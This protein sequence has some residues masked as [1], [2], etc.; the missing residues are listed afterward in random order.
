[1]SRLATNSRKDTL[2]RLH[3]DHYDLLI[4]GGGITGA[5]IALDAVTRGLKVALIEKKDF[6]SGTSSRSTKLIHG[7]LRY[8]KQLEIQLVREVGRERAI[9]H[10]LAPHLVHAEKMLMPLVEGGTYGKLATA[11]GLSV[12]DFLAKVKGDDRRQMLSKPA[13]LEREPLLRDDILKGGGYYAEYRTD[14]ARLTMAILK[15]AVQKGADVLNYL[16]AKDFIYEGKKLA[17]VTA[18][19]QLTATTIDIKAK[20]IV[21]AAGPWVDGLREKDGSK[22][23]KRLFLSKGVHIVVPHNRLPVRQT[24]YFDVPDGR[25]VFVIPRLEV[26]YIGTT[27]TEYKGNKDKVLA[28]LSDVDYLLEAANHMFPSID[29]KRKDV[30]SSWAGLRPL[31]HEE[32]KSASEMSRKD[33]IFESESGLISIAGG[34]LTGYRKMAQRVVDLVADRY[35]KDHT[36]KLPSCHTHEVQLAG[37][38]WSSPK[39]VKTYLDQFIQKARK[40]GLDQ[41]HAEYLV[42]NYGK[43]SE[44]ILQLLNPYHNRQR[45]GP[46][47]RRSRMGPATRTDHPPPRLLQP[48]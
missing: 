39:E 35:E 37:G 28:D 1:M 38:P 44:Q 42:Y 40:K 25:M 18:E 17:A 29:L 10:N 26:T 27:D 13:T 9:V 12:Y 23:G 15:T 36:K 6:A 22:S 19:D 41:I 48:P 11:V 14:D 31:I 24:A 30:V 2:H 21:S 20:Y 33:E 43:D 16:S 7:G 5:G 3:Q 46:R 45:N 8:L 47:L 32:G 4:I 34:K